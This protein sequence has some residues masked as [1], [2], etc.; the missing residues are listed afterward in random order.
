MRPLKAPLAALTAALTLTLASS[1]IVHA[2]ESLHKPGMVGHSVD[3]DKQLDHPC[4]GRDLLFNSHVDA[5]YATHNQAGDLDIQVVNGQ[6]VQPMDTVCLRLAPESDAQGNDLSRVVLPEPAGTKNHLEFLGQPGHT[7]WLAPQNM[8]FSQGNKP[9]WA[10][11]GAFDPAHEWDVPTQYGD[12]LTFELVD[13]SIPAGAAMHAFASVASDPAPERLFSIPDGPQKF[14]VYVGSHGHNS[15]AFTKPGIYKTT[16]KVTGSLHDGHP[17]ESAP[18]ELIWLVGDDT[19]VGLPEGTTTG[20]TSGTR[21]APQPGRP[22]V[23]AP[24]LDSTKRRIERGHMDLALGANYLGEMSAYLKATENKEVHRYES[25][26]FVFVVGEHAQATPDLTI[27]GMPQRVWVL[28]QTQNENPNVPWVGFSAEDGADMFGEGPI[29]LRIAEFTGPGRMVSGHVGLTNFTTALDSDDLT[30]TVT[31]APGAHDHQ[32][33]FFSAPGTYTVTFEYSGTDIYGEPYRVPLTAHF[34]VEGQPDHTQQAGSTRRVNPNEVR[35]VV[36]DLT[37]ML[38]SA[39]KL[40]ALVL[41]ETSTY[42]KPVAQVPAHASPQGS[43]PNVTT[44]SAPV[45]QAA[46][47]PSAPAARPA[48]AP[49]PA[50]PQEATPQEPTPQEATL[51][52]GAEELAGGASISEQPGGVAPNQGGIRR[53]E[54]QPSPTGMTAGGWWAGLAVGMGSMGLLGGLIMWLSARSLLKQAATTRRA[55]GRENAES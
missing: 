8:P 28:P 6:H 14:P 27:P 52:P 55:S 51:P 38:R 49:A 54:A 32:A 12:E 34:A 39:D 16:W 35:G 48:S 5:L 10:G 2:E 47:A 37:T 36:T 18:R 42:K 24:E 11:T 46:S 29:T 23:P 25:G 40:A 13:Y 1:P 45:Q 17:V 44:A 20:A 15:W 26:Q 43:T 33:F 50:A 3:V 9:I 4:A 31:Y 7:I 41:A 53:V 21:P 22:G 30:T 19:Q